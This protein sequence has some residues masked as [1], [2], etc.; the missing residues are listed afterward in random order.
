MV[1]PVLQHG[2]RVPICYQQVNWGRCFLAV[3]VLPA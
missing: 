3:S 1:L 2:D